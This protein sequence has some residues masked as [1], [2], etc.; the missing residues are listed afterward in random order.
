MSNLFMDTGRN[1][2]ESMETL[3]V[4]QQ[5]LLDG[6]R[7]AQMFPI[8]TIELTPPI[9]MERIV[10]ERGV[11]HYNPTYVT[12]CNLCELSRFG[13]ENEFLNLGP[14]NKSDIYSRFLQ[15]E[16][17]LAVTEYTKYG[18]EIRS[19]VATQSTLPEQEL[20]FKKTKYPN[21]TL[22]LGPLPIRVTNAFRQISLEQRRM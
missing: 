11:F 10:L 13:R 12:E 15:G 4:Q 20:Y 18:V 1:V 8:G 19:A 6:S 2:P 21:S 5:C 14:Y 17:I 9:G 7:I 22:V 3:L 16:A